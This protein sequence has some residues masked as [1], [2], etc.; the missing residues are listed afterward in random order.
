[1]VRGKQQKK[2]DGGRGRGRGRGGAHG[3]G[4]RSSGNRMDK[5]VWEF[6][7]AASDNN[8]SKAKAK[9]MKLTIRNED[10]EGF[11]AQTIAST[12]APENSADRAALIAFLRSH[13]SLGMRMTAGWA[14]TSNADS[15]L[16][17]SLA[18][19]QGLAQ[20]A[21]HGGIAAIN[22]TL[23]AQHAAAIQAA[24]AAKSTRISAP[25][26]DSALPPDFSRNS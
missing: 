15:S 12:T 6:D 4:S 13:P 20:N 16:L 17:S 26:K 8:A 22:P 5:G 19:F 7:A 11:F 21:A 1:M 2:G 9:T 14:P 18:A 23:L 10:G 24:L 25:Q 3:S